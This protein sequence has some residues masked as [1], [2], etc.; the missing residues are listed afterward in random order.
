MVDSL[1]KLNLGVS[2]FGE[3]RTTMW[4]VC[5]PLA[6]PKA[7]E[8]DNAAKTVFQVNNMLNTSKTGSMA[9]LEFKSKQ[10]FITKYSLKMEQ[11]Q[12]ESYPNITVI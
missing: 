12:L 3:T 11:R 9:L 2:T 5:L 7:S 4:I 6:C 1:Q 10:S 8:T